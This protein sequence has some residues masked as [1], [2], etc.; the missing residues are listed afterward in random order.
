MHY[1][2]FLSLIKY[3]VIFRI[4][5]SSLMERKFVVGIGASAGGLNAIQSFFESMPDD[6]GMT[7]VVIQ[8]LA[9]NFKS[10]MPEILAKS[11]KMPIKTASE[12]LVLEPNT[13]YLNRNDSDLVVVGDALKLLPR[14]NNQNLNLP[15][16][17]FFHSLGNEF[18]VFSSGIIVSGTGSDGSRGIVT[19]KEQGGN[20]F[21]QTPES[22]EFDG[23]PSMSITTNLID[24]VLDPKQIAAKLQEIHRDLRLTADSWE[25]GS[26]ED[27]IFQEILE[28]VYKNFFIDFSSY[29]RNTLIRRVQKRMS[30]TNRNGIGDYFQ[31][32]LANPHEITNLKQ[33][34]LIGVT[35]FFRDTDAF[36]SLRS[37]VFPK[38]FTTDRKE[39][40]RVWVAG[41]STGEE[42]YSVAILI[43]EYLRE[44]RLSTDFKIFATDADP[45]AISF[46]G[47]GKYQINA[48]QELPRK[49]F[50][51]YFTSDGNIIKVNKFLRE[52]IIFSQHNL[53][54]DPA[55]LN[56]DLISCRNL[57]IYLDSYA[58]SSILKT[59]QYSSRKDSFLFLGS[60]ESLG[61]YS[62]SFKPLD[63]NWRIFQCLE[64]SNSA[65][66]A[67]HH[68][69]S[70]SAI[71]RLRSHTPRRSLGQ[72]ASDRED[73]INGI[74]VKKYV[75]SCVI[76]D[77]KMNIVY[78]KGDIVQQM[79]I[80]DGVFQPNL[81]NM[82]PRN[83]ASKI[84]NGIRTCEKNGKE[85]LLKSIPSE[86]ED[87]N[88]VFDLTISQLNQSVNLEYILEFHEEREAE[89]DQVIIEPSEFNQLDF[90][91]L[92]ELEVEL[93]KTKSELNKAVE[94]LESSNEE[95]QSSNEELMASNEELQS[96][97][98]ELQ[99]VNEELFTVNAE[100]QHKNRE[101][102][103]VTDESD[104]LLK[105][106]HIGT[107]FLDAQL[108]IRKYT[109]A[110]LIHYDLEAHD[111]GRPLKSFSPKFE[112][113]AQERLINDCLSCIE[114]PGTYEDEIK[115]KNG[116]VFL[117]Q[118]RP[119]VSSSK[120]IEGVVITF[121]NLSELR[122]AQEQL[123]TSERR[124]E[125]LFESLT[126]GMFHGSI[127]R[128]GN[129]SLHLMNNRLQ[130][131]LEVKSPS[132]GLKVLLNIPTPDG[133]KSW[134]NVFLEV[135]QDYK[136]PLQYEIDFKGRV[137]ALKL[138]APSENEVVGIFSDISLLTEAARD[139]AAYSQ[140]LEESL[141]AEKELNQVKS[142][143]VA[144]A[145]HQFR[146]PLA[147][148]KSN[149]NLI[150]L[151][152]KVD[153]SDSDE[154]LKDCL[155]RMEVAS[156][157]L[158]QIIN[159]T[160]TL[161]FASAVEK[162]LP[163]EKVIVTSSI[164]EA[165]GINDVSQGPIKITIKGVEREII[166]DSRLLTQVISNLLSNALK[167]SKGAKKLPVVIVAYQKTQV[168]VSVRDFGIGIPKSEIQ[169]IGNAFYR[170][171]N[172]VKFGGNGL[173][174]SIVNEY[175]DTLGGRLE[176]ESEEGKGSTFTVILP[177]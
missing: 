167:Y 110:I 154:K 59:F 27:K 101:L 166:S 36:E 168:K 125:A 23:M 159:D 49:L 98:E 99:S 68:E 55:F 105:S 61:D 158:D 115:G 169:S 76:V 143:V 78:S 67:F 66:P 8:H 4:Q 100:L 56:I 72:S 39:S 93:Q 43:D 165:I 44:N 119:F 170:A 95:L 109:P 142:R 74:L 57:L 107:L 47:M 9:P 50:T 71:G 85:V 106:T 10:L 54:A 26:N 64:R 69:R 102:I 124:F 45:E 144:T 156:E 164:Q 127:D 32:L 37:N 14:E 141:K 63:A 77:E 75:P 172:T 130:E 60:S 15:I 163:K 153:T 41:C 12:G 121:V 5:K 136:E 108:N 122:R 70:K 1:H 30:I 13:I 146:T 171:S 88:R 135:K 52:K 120:S 140:Q 11:T 79:K 133:K 80:A 92:T 21:A 112:Q 46:A 42:A 87:S 138:S 24:F 25:I 89:K 83:I 174:I 111:R 177:G 118:V 48:V 84:R 2:D 73:F 7:F 22:A 147:V 139:K 116:Q 20:T 31:F 28:L 134:S 149:L 150:N 29:K 34:F 175:L 81:L 173:G 97:N 148:I 157:S 131:I 123:V 6:S 117:R 53:L 62:K 91:R 104:N 33:D 113:T 94:E 114:E 155:Q 128:K 65:D 176:I 161:S 132:K 40:V 96:T 38:L 19:I 17:T 160:L 90:S 129:L 82:L 35:T 103:E 152:R 51:R 145:S 58:Q 18:G 3:L 86:R 126:E 137:Y 16:D 162:D 151:L